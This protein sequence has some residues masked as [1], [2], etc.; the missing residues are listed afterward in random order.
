[1]QDQKARRLQTITFRRS[2]AERLLAEL[3]HDESRYPWIRLGVLAVGLLIV[4]FSF[5]LLPLGLAWLVAAVALAAF[6]LAAAM[7]RRVID[8]IEYTQTFI[9]ILDTYLSRANLIWTGIPAPSSIETPAEHPFASDLNVLGPRSL[10]QLLDTTASAGGS[11][12][13]AD[14]L[15]ATE[16]DTQTIAHRQALVQELLERPSLRL[17]LELDGVLA[18]PQRPARWNSDTLIEW[19]DRHT[20]LKSLRPI[21]IILGLLAVANITLFALNALGILPPFWIATLAI[22]LLIQASK[23]REA[24]EVFEEAY[25]LAQRLGQLRAILSGLETY[26]YQ[27]APGL[28][29]LCAPF[30]RNQPR[31]SDALRKIGRIASAASLRNNPL[32]ALMLNLVV[33][34]DLFFAYQ[35]DIYKRDLRGVLP[36]WLD[37]WH[38]LEA[39]TALAN[40]TALNPGSTFP[41][42]LTNQAQ[43]EDQPVLFVRSA[44]HP[45]IPD[46]V[47]VNNDFT[48]KALGEVIIITGS[49]M[50]GK[51]TFLR[52][53]GANM[54]LAYAG[55]SVP[56]EILRV[57][58]FRLFTSMNL[59]DSLNDGISFFYAE[60]RRLKA[61]LETLEDNHPTPLFFLIDEIFRGTNNRERRV[62]S[63]AYTEALAG[64]RGTGLISTHDLELANLTETIPVV[65]NYHFREDVHDGRMVFDYKIR[66]GASPTTNALRIMRLA[67]LP[68]PAEETA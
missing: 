24:S 38:E 18:N 13:L 63:R 16:P 23:Y 42:I 9:Y 22:Y 26:P 12:C 43:A 32:L 54:V 41:Q 53:L 25:L 2:R 15:M 1:M 62:G 40:F 11:R 36:T 34:W 27:N 30:C 57:H 17:R 49:N 45:L 67:G 33:P 60:V 52:T 8:Q 31:P 61:L 5:Q 7:H 48:I 35:L 19:L 3:K 46:L 21:L 65:S 28:A 64:K 39:L 66:A 47:R 10:H 29:E 14:W 37:A 58:P 50:S 6:G 51:S 56:A 55:C 20:N 44:G 59:A 4:F 68:V